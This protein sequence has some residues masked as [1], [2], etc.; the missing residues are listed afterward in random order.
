MPMSETYNYLSPQK[1]PVREESWSSFQKKHGSP[2]RKV[3]F[4]SNEACLCG[5]YSL[6]SFFSGSFG[7]RK[8]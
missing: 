3:M 4:A 1:Y 7:V 5:R 2:K 6:I 8:K